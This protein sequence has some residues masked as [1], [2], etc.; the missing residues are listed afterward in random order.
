MWRRGM[1]TTWASEVLMPLPERIVI[2]TSAFY[3]LL[4]GSD[5]FHAKAREAFERMVDRDQELWTTSYVS[6][7]TIALVHHRLGFQTLSQFLDTTGQSVRVFWVESALHREAWLRL[8]ANHGVGL[9]FVDWTAALVS[10]VLEAHV[11]TFDGDFINEGVPVI[12]R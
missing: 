4:S 10:Q 12:P 5:S 8:S 1:T 9:S 7:E 3:A 11:F 2:D 6:V